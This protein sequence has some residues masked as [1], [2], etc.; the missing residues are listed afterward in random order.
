MIK[1]LK[2]RK[3]EKALTTLV[4]IL[5]CFFLIVILSSVLVTMVGN[6]ANFVGKYRN[7]VVSTYAAK[8][9]IEESLYNLFED[10]NWNDGFY[11]KQLTDSNATYT[12]TFNQSQTLYPYSTNN[13]LGTSSVTGYGGRIVPSGAV[14]LICTGEFNNKTAREG[15]MLTL[16][17]AFKNA[18]FGDE[19]IT[20]ENNV[21]ID[22]Y[23]SSQGSYDSTHQDSDGDLRTNAT[24]EGK[25]TLTGSV[26]VYG[27]IMVGPGGSPAVVQGTG[28]TGEIKVASSSFPL[29]SVEVPSGKYRGSKYIWF[30]N[31]LRPGVYRNVTVD[32]GICVLR[33][34]N[35]VM[36]NFTV[37]NG[38][39]VI[40]INWKSPTKIF[41]T[42][43]LNFNNG[44]YINSNQRPEKLSIYGA[45]SATSFNMSNGV[46]AFVALYA[47]KATVTMDDYVDF[48]GG[49]AVN[50][51]NMSNNSNLHH[52]RSLKNI[53]FEGGATSLNIVS[54]WEEY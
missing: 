20:L 25:V 12:V 6:T 19:E 47:P 22:S 8:A 11:R 45:D 21:T 32:G 1:I 54:R 36:E 42:N 53:L 17:N 24:E 16:F 37:K 18:G 39:I 38:G 7:Q 35:Y 23:D 4:I 15:V 30:M 14:Y 9:G 10:Y 44:A 48:Y 27:D 34:G 49:I 31:V 33:K 28:Y 26:D 43:S 29:P 2:R 5:F 13:S 41:I 50:K 52:D 51:I 40:T 3:K 46:D